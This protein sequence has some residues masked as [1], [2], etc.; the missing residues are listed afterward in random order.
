MDM[1]LNPPFTF[2]L[3]LFA[4]LVAENFEQKMSTKLFADIYPDI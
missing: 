4:M 2:W 1:L 3:V